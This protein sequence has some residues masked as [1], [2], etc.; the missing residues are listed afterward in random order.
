MILGAECQRT[1]VQY[2]FNVI[3]STTNPTR[4]ELGLNPR[5]RGERP[6]NKK[7]K[8]S[9]RTLMSNLSCVCLTFF[10]HRATHN[11]GRL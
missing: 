6:T 1:G 11:A 7:Q 5:V 3:L 10:T 9:H 4:N 2:H 8:P